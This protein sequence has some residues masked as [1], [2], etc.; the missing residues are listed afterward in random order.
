MKIIEC[1]IASRSTFTK[2]ENCRRHAISQIMYSSSSSNND[3]SNLLR[4][5]DN[6][7]PEIEL[8]TSTSERRQYEN[9]GDLY[10]IIIATEHLERAYASDAITQKEYMVECNKLLAQFK[11]AEKAALGSG[12]S[13]GA[14]NSSG[15][16]GGR[17]TIAKTTE[18]FM[19]LYQMDCPR[20]SHRLLHMGVPEPTKNDNGATT[21]SQH[22]VTVAETVQHFITT[23]DAVKL[24]LR[25]VDEL[26]PLL[27]DLMA[28][29]NQLP[30]ITPS[31]TTDGGSS[32]NSSGLSG[33]VDKVRKWLVKL[34]N[35]R[36]ID[37]ITEDDAR[38]LSH[39]LDSSY[40]EF[41]RYL[42]SKT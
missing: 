4:A 7:Q 1:Q 34:N 10:T 26:Q 24:D 28:A 38:Q 40:S 2:N 37:M 14:G 16:G 27:S 39:D 9:M 32:N 15:G 20:A 30:D 31:A 6:T 5:I 33:P 17:T 12:G 18:E 23:M 22:A 29:L 21:S 19:R 41:S 3:N 13:G 42:R 36:A 25:A 35:M 8:Y 11:I